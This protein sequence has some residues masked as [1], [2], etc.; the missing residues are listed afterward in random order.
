MK[1]PVFLD[2]DNSGSIDPADVATSFA[3]AETEGD[4]DPQN[5]GALHRADAGA[6]CLAAAAM[7]AVVPVA[8]IAIVLLQ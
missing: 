2:W 6:G 4:G 7:L 8:S 1:G 5:D 3:V